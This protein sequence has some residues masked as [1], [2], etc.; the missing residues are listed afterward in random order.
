MRGRGRTQPAI[1]GIPDGSGPP[2]RSTR[3]AAASPEWLTRVNSLLNGD[4]ATVRFNA[5]FRQA[6]DR[7]AYPVR[8]S[9]F[10]ALTDLDRASY[11]VAGEAPRLAELRTAIAQ[12]AADNAVLAG[13]IAD[14]NGWFFLLY[15]AGT[16]WLNEFDPAVR[17]AAADHQVRIGA[18]RDPRWKAFKEMCP[19][20]L[21]PVRDPVLVFTLLPLIGAWG[22][23]RYGPVAAVAGAAAVLAWLVP[24]RLRRRHL[25]SGQLAHPYIAFVV[26]SYVL[27]TLIFPIAARI[28]Q[29]GRLAVVIAVAAGAGAVLTGAVWPAQ[30][31][32]YARM[33]ARDALRP[34]AGPTQ[35]A[36]P[37]AES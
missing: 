9:V 28:G 20:T 2:P 17:A 35:P 34:P 13:S 25:L 36:V 1:S 21:H 24:V 22:G 23:A 27:A 30:Q 32:F 5:A 14:S 18:A 12:L 19:R 26:F 15:A 8:V 29:N 3:A 10:I 4:V 33:R 11:P 7:A 37:P 6:R 16:D 31:K